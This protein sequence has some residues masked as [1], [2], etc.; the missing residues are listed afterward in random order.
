MSNKIP[1]NIVVFDPKGDYWE[2]ALVDEHTAMVLNARGAVV[3]PT[4]PELFRISGI[5]GFM[6][7]SWGS[8]IVFDYPT[9]RVIAPLSIYVTPELRTLT[10]AA[11]LI[12]EPGSED[13]N[14]IGQL[15]LVSDSA[16]P[17]STQGGVG[18]HELSSRDG[19][20]ANVINIQEIQPDEA[21]N[22][23]A[24]GVSRVV[25]SAPGISGVGLYGTGQ[26]V[27]L[28]WAAVSLSE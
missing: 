7:R 28:L 12:R 25:A 18:A 15:R 19:R 20:F 13:R 11:R 8:G 4:S 16:Q 21:G 22:L 10:W 1:T 23:I 24:R 26:G 5:G 27:R 9:P 2:G 14:V 17:S 6:K 3:L